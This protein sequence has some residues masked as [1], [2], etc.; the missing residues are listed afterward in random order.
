M[1][2]PQRPGAI[3]RVGNQSRQFWFVGN[4]ERDIRPPTTADGLAVLRPEGRRLAGGQRTSS[5]PI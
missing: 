4:R 3:G 1:G 5:A 2:G